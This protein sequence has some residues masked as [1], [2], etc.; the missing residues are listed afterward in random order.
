VPGTAQ[1]EQQSS[2]IGAACPICQLVFVTDGSYAEHLEVAHH[3]RDDEGTRTTLR[4]ARNITLE[5]TAAVLVADPPA[6]APLGAVAP[7]PTASTAPTAPSAPAEPPTPEPASAVLGVILAVLVLL[8]F[9]GSGWSVKRSLDAA[10]ESTGVSAEDAE[11]LS[12]HLAG[13]AS[14]TVPPPEHAFAPPSVSGLQLDECPPEGDAVGT[15]RFSYVLGGGANWAP[16]P[17]ATSAA[18]RYREGIESLRRDVAV[19]AIAVR[20]TVTGAD[21]LID[22]PDLTPDDC[23]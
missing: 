8:L 3:L 10:E 23:P 16:S 6:R 13:L 1:E 15:W 18:G 21:V 22:V 19:T 20:D 9:F 7:G 5:P 11:A 17:S 14:T 4:A 12:L 2:A